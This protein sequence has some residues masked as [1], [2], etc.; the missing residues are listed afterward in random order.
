MCSFR[1]CP[2]QSKSLSY[3]PDSLTLMTTS[4]LEVKHLL[5]ENGQHS[6]DSL[7]LFTELGLINFVIK[8]W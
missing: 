3:A 7:T 8:E 1:M 4:T 5:L 2:P 6:I